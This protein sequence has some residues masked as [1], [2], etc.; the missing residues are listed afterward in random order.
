MPKTG[1]MMGASAA[2]AAPTLAGAPGSAARQSRATAPPQAAPYSAQAPAPP[3][4]ADELPLATALEWAQAA[5]AALKP[6]TVAVLQLTIV[7]LADATDSFTLTPVGVYFGD[8]PGVTRPDPFFGGAGELIATLGVIEEVG[9]VA[10]Q[11]EVV[12]DAVDVRLRHD[13]AFSLGPFEV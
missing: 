1:R 9:E 4:A 7:N 11:I 13:I 3:P 8:G 10:E 2:C 6:G 5:V 12:V